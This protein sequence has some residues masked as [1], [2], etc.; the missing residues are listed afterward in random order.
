MKSR[1]IKFLQKVLRTMSVLILKKYKPSIVGITGSVGKTS[2]KEAAFLVLSSKFSVRKNEKN[3]N[4]EIGI[5]LTII[6]AES[7]NRS[8]WKWIG[9]I[10]R[11]FFLI[12]FPCK[13]PEILV[14][15][16]GV[17]RPGDMKYLTGFIPLK[18]GVITNIS[19]SHIEYFKNIEH[20]AKEKGKII[21]NLPDFGTAILNADD[22]RTMAR[23]SKTQAKVL[24]FGFSQSAQLKATEVSFAYE[25][26]I[27]EGINFKL[28]YKG[29]IVPVRLRH[30]Y[31]AHQIYAALIASAIGIIYKINLVDIAGALENFFPPAGR[32]NLIQ[33]INGSYIFDD[34]YNASPVSTAAALE[35]ASNFPC[36]RKIAV[37]GDMLELGNAMEEG[38]KKVAQKI[39]NLKIDLFYGVGERMEVIVKELMD[40]GFSAKNIFYFEN[41]DLAELQ[42]E[43]EL[44]AGDLVLVKGS[45]GMR[46]EK[47]VEKI[48]ARPDKAPELLCRQSKEWKN[49]PFVRP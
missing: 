12:I 21:E 2:A 43:K 34:T 6:G 24:T 46:M 26:D 39:F 40:L 45:Q 13:Y 38:Y 47:V 17:D 20:I 11:S 29:R 48:M 30:I 35:V 31:A 22:S 3:Y 32:M 5:P 14:L 4:N 1:K 8:I 28:D 18:A 15:E 42:L 10:F 25:E 44:R 33:G 16:M 36:R 7:G 23:K 27:N 9:I 49:K 19:T 37:L 41:P